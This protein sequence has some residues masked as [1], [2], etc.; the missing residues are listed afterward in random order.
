M[1][2]I[3][4]YMAFLS[5]LMTGIAS[6]GDNEDF[7]LPH[8]LTDQEQAELDR[9]D[10]I[11]RAQMGEINVKFKLQYTV[12]VTTSASA[13]D[14]VLLKIETDKIAEFYG[15]TEAELLAGIAGESGAPEVKGFAIE[16]T[17]RADNG[18]ASTTNSPWGHWWDTNGDV[19]NWGETAFIFC[20]FDTETGS[21]YVGQYPGRLTDGQTITVAEC[22]KYKGLRVGV[23]I[24]VKAVAPGKITA[25]VVRT[26]D[27]TIDVLAKSNYDADPLKFNL[28]QAMSDLGITSMD[29]VKFVTFKNDGLLTQ[30]TTA[31]P[32]GFWYNLEGFAGTWGDNASFYVN[33]GDNAED[34][35][36]IGQFP[37]RMAGG[38]SLIVHFGIMANNKIVMLKVTVNVLA[39]QDPETP[40]TGEPKAVEKAVELTKPH[41]GDYSSVKYDVKDLLR[42][43]FKKTTYQIHQAIMSGEL[44]TLSRFE[45]TETAPTYTAD[46]PGYWLKGRRHCRRVGRK[47]GV[48]QFRA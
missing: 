22:L 39:Y 40:P 30:E 16:G 36:G 19:C 44:E 26:Q 24:I 15:I 47:F 41:S 20:E 21:F 4:L 29:A 12:N 46:A 31:G 35:I 27:L 9:Q 17:T 43:A 11:R 6:C 48:V 23:E 5:L 45:V 14:G 10:S 18:K 37:G 34:E 32:K 38:Q 2:K 33:Y 3:Y 13:Y 28:T 25:P 1:K 8:K 7:S 42:D